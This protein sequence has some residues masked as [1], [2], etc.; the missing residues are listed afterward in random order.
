[1]GT[2]FLLGIMLARIGGKEVFGQYAYIV[3][4]VS[5]FSPLCIMGLNNITTKYVVKRP[6]NSHFYVKSILM[7]RGLGASASLVLGGIFIYLSSE[8]IN[9]SQE[10]ICLLLFQFFQ[11]FYAI[12][13]FY[14]AKNQVHQTLSVRLL[15]FIISTLLKFLVIWYQL[16]IYLLIMAH[17]VSYLITAIG[18]LYLYYNKGNQKMEKKP[19][20]LH[21]S[22]AMFHQ[23]KWLLFA[24]VAALIYLKI[25]QIM[26]AHLHSIDSVATYA[27]AVRLSEVWYI[28]PVLIANAFY[29][30][31][32]NKFQK[33]PQEFEQFLIRFLSYLFIIA[34]F[35]SCLVWFIAPGLIQ[36][37]Y[38]AEYL[39]SATILSIHIFATCFIFQRALYSKWLITKKLYK[40]SLY[41]QGFG[42]LFNVLLN[43]WL[44]PLYG[45]I[46]AAWATL[47]SYSVASYFSLFISNNTRPFAFMMSKAMVIWPWTI[48][49]LLKKSFLI[50]ST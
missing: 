24:G 35:M 20:N 42:A 30:K 6:D 2:S 28:F 41:S 38:G 25:D 34:L 26:L 18:Y 39:E 37:I 8:T 29:P 3:S 50:R 23:G 11:L 22:L 43:L 19:A 15:A 5:L 14:L 21:S 48:K 9:L 16:G 47:I 32:L 40:Y 31:L 33:S 46:G 12:E 17:G 13:Y 4:F 27:A 49:R 44:I 36:F 45:G 10:M 7:I 1:M